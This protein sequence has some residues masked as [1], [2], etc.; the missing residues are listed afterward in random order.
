MAASLRSTRSVAK[1]VL[2]NRKGRIDYRLFGLILTVNAGANIPFVTR[3]SS[4]FQQFSRIVGASLLVDR[5][6][7][8]G[9]DLLVRNDPDIERYSMKIGGRWRFRAIPNARD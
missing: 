6:L 3:R 9:E 2:L 4:Y 8:G 7:P 1:A 5:R